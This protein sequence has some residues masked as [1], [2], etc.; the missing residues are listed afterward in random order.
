M[1][2]GVDDLS[3]A[4]MEELESYSEE[5]EDT[6]D[7]DIDRISKILVDELKNNP[8]IP[9]RTGDYKK[10]FY[11]KTVAKGRGYKRKVVANKKYQLTHLLEEDHPMPQGG[12]SRA[13]PHWKTAEERLEELMEETELKL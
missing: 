2:I 3:S 9:K 4:I 10:S 6:I 12:R 7:K 5:V 11:T 8:K 1:S 13:F